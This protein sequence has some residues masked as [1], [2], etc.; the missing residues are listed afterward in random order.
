SYLSDELREL[1]ILR[2]ENPELSLRELGQILTIP[3]SRSGV[4]HRLKKITQMAEDLKKSN[5][6]KGE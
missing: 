6:S 3:I 4:N 2:I 5:V 1:A